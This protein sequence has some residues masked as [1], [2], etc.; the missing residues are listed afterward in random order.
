MSIKNYVGEMICWSVIALCLSAIT[1]IIIALATIG[2]Q[3][4]NALHFKVYANTM[5]CGSL[6][7]HPSCYGG[8]HL[9]TTPNGITRRGVGR[10]NHVSNYKS[11][12]LVRVP[13]T[14]R[15]ELP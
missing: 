15:K 7:V 9:F 11:L 4:M 3:T 6:V 2:V 5:Y 12:Q 1:F 10:V 13:S 14:Q 8:T